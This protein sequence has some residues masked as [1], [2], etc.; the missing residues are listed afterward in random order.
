MTVYFAYRLEYEA[1]RLEAN[2]VNSMYIGWFCS[3]KAGNSPCD[4]RAFLKDVYGTRPG[5]VGNV[6]K[7]GYAN[8]GSFNP[9]DKLK[10]PDG[11]RTMESMIAMAKDLGA[12]GFGKGGTQVNAASLFYDFQQTNY[13]VIM[14]FLGNRVQYAVKKLGP[15]NAAVQRYL[16]PIKS[17]LT[18]IAAERVADDFDGRYKRLADIMKAQTGV[19]VAFDT[20]ATTYTGR[21]YNTK[22][23]WPNTIKN[24]RTTSQSDTEM[25]ANLDKIDKAVIDNEDTPDERHER[26]QKAVDVL[27]SRLEL[28]PTDRDPNC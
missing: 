14:E 25:L 21:K 27:I 17:G 20:E 7:G 24:L 13:K 9:N 6:N 22:I 5:S 8:D 12:K 1:A 3:E 2:P 4:F 18:G 16:S 10:Y 28:P 23:D 15:G 11:G 19:T 26:A